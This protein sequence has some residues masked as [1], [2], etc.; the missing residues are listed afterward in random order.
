M[1]EERFAQDGQTFLQI[2]SCHERELEIFGI[3]QMGGVNR[4]GCGHGLDSR[5][6]QVKEGDNLQL[7]N[8]TFLI[9]FFSFVGT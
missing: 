9:D 4:V 6:F 2:F 5:T 1:G 7:K 3:V 8:E